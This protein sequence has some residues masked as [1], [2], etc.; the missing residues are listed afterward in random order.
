MLKRIKE[1][2]RNTK[3]YGFFGN[4]LYN[5]RAKAFDL[6]HNV[7]TAREVRLHELK[8]DSPNVEYGVF[9]AGT[10]PKSFRRIFEHLDVNYEDFVFIDLG[11]GKGRALLVAAERPFKKIIGVEFA[12]ELN[13]IAQKNILKYKNPDQTC[14]QIESICQDAALFKL[15]EEPSVFYVFNAFHAEI[16]AK[17]TENIERSFN[18]KPREIYFIYA[19]PV[20]NEILQENRFFEEIYTDTW[21]S[22]YKNRSSA[23]SAAENAS[24]S[25]YAQFKDKLCLLFSC[26]G[27]LNWDAGLPNL[28]L[29]FATLT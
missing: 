15:P 29:N 14:H 18:E 6:E 4:Y 28:C 2:I 16:V 21:Y 3:A 11:S 7:E 25:V 17:V 12:A 10:D 24:S 13:E 23:I 19:N 22:I 26:A 27:L 5:S 9:Y 20:H 8:I 1:K